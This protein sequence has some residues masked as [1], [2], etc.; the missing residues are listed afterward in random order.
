MSETCGA[1]SARR[2]HALPASPSSSQ[3]TKRWSTAV[4]NANHGVASKDK[5]KYTHTCIHACIHTYIHTYITSQRQILHMKS[6]Q[7]PN[8][9]RQARRWPH[10]HAHHRSAKHSTCTRAASK[11]KRCQCLCVR[12]ACVG[13][14]QRVDGTVNRLPECTYDR[15]QSTRGVCVQTLHACENSLPAN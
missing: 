9:A 10:R 6:S 13:K 8:T 2:V 12:C 14:C 3:N 7:R 15:L 11:A 1:V 4:S 5:R